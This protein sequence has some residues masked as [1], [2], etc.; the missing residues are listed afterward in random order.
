MWVHE[1]SVLADLVDVYKL[2]V[3][4]TMWQLEKKAPSSCM[5]VSIP[6]LDADTLTS[7]I[8]AENDETDVLAISRT[9]ECVSMT[10][11]SGSREEVRKGM[12]EPWG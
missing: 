5:L 1:A 8:A 6:A 9:C 12:H 3:R 7:N 10:P 2:L 4:E 11:K